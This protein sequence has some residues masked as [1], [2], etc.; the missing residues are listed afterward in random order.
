M[1]SLVAVP[2]RD[3]GGLLSGTGELENA[4][5]MGLLDTALFLEWEPEDTFEDDDEVLFSE[6][7]HL[8]CVRDLKWRKVAEGCGE[9]RKNKFTRKVRIQMRHE[10]GHTLVA[11]FF[12]VCAPPFGVIVPLRSA[13]WKIF[14]IGCSWDDPKVQHVALVFASSELAGEFKV[15]FEEADRVNKVFLEFG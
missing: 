3:S 5:S 7:C 6:R 14:V 4:V 11:S 15:A 9:L 12:A 2:K 8:A 13:G 1:V 10:N